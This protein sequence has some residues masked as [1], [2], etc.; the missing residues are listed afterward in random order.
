MKDTNKV[1]KADMKMIANLIPYTNPSGIPL[2]FY[3]GDRLIQGIP[4]EFHPRVNRRLVDSN[5]LYIEIVGQSEAGLEVRAEYI[6]YRDFPVT[7]W[8]AYITN[9]GKDNTPMI[10]QIRI[11]NNPIQGSNPVLIHGNG[12]TV[13]ENG[14]EYFTDPIDKELHIAPRDGLACHFAFPYMRLLFEEYGVNIAVGWPAQWETIFAPCAA[15]VQFT[16]GQQRT[17][18]YLKPG[19]T[20]RTPRINLMGFTGDENR[21]R[22][23]WRR[24]YFKHIIPREN[25]EAIPPKLCLHTWLIDGKPEFT[26]ITEENQLNAIDTYINRGLKPDIWW[27]DAGWYP[28]DF[29]WTNTGTWKPYRQQLPNGLGPV[30][31]KCEEEDIQFLLW[32]EPER[33]REKT[34]LDV[35][36]TEWMLHYHDKDGNDHEDRLL[37][38]ADEECLNWLIEMVDG[39]IKEYHIHIYRQDFNFPPLRYWIENEEPDRTGMLENLHTQGYLRFWDELLVRNPGL[40][41]DSCSSGGR[42]NDL[43]TMRRAVPLHY[44]DI[45]YGV[46]PIKQKQHREMFE[47]IPY[48][49]AHTINWD[50]ERG[51]YDDTRRPVD[52]FAYHCAMAPAITSMIEYY[53]SDDL[54]NIG[55]KMH[56]IWR[57]AAQL[58]I[59]GDYYPLTECRKSAEDYYAMQFD[60][61]AAG[62]GFIQIVRNTK[63]KE[64]SCTV[65]PWID[66]DA[67][68]DFI[69]R[70]T[71]NT[72]SMSGSQLKQGFSVS[73]PRRSGI[74][75]FYQK[76]N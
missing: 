55:K 8:V 61:A 1:T 2:A 18:M 10:S 38:L 71:G 52:E 47:W 19:E 7:E 36:H 72:M 39:Y 30:G 29:N 22:N 9:H 16:A 51:D 31:K 46:H 35:E 73:I 23:M 58:M 74:I 64:D 4:E 3:Y 67:A 13:L 57:E 45:G 26:G 41:I 37:N 20:V 60:D 59:T 42:R 68:Y 11:M 33:V 24:W 34:E 48:F 75:W 70:E 17:N 50:N 12:D 25:G 62:K 21:G 28:C 69:D 54:Y 49:R 15:G 14:Y 32:F 76:R 53:D 63:V 43:E 44:T 5:M 56:P 66:E 6:E 40:W 65:Y 27:I